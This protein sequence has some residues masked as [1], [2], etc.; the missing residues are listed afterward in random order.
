MSFDVT[1]GERFPMVT[2]R[3]AVPRDEW[4]AFIPNAHPGY[5]FWEEYERTQQRLRES[6]QAYGADRRHGPPRE[7]P[8]L[9]QGRVVCGRCGRCM[10]E[11]ICEQGARHRPACV[12]RQL[13]QASEPAGAGSL[14]TL[15]KSI[16]LSLDSESQRHGQHGFVHLGI[17]SHRLVHVGS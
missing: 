8:T 17:A 16:F 15:P 9:L 1:G 10:S 5:I 2:R 11:R 7:G 13:S 6:A 4:H 3:V 12:T 14:G